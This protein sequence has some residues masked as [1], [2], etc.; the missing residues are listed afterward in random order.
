MPRSGIVPQYSCPI[1]ASS[2]ATA[3]THAFTM[4]AITTIELSIEVVGA[5]SDLWSKAY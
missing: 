1:T 2:T 3:S 5:P 4:E